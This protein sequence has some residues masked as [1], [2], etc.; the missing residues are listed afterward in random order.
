MT[1]RVLTALLLL[2]ACSVPEGT[3]TRHPE[4]KQAIL[5]QNGI[6]VLL[7]DAS[8]CT[9]NRPGAAREWAGQLGGCSTP[10]VYNASRM[11]ASARPRTIMRA[12]ET[13]GAADAHISISSPDGTRWVFVT[14]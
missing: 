2:S 7:E 5:Y 11:G 14:P 13:V 10:Y 4:P 8:L 3:N 12:A 1:R 6:T 9:A